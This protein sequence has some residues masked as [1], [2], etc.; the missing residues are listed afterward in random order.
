[1]RKGV[2]TGDVSTFAKSARQ[3]ISTSLHLSAL[4]VPAVTIQ[5]SGSQRESSRVNGVR[6]TQFPRSSLRPPRFTSRSG[7][8]EKTKITKRTH[9]ENGALPKN[10]GNYEGFSFCSPKNEPIFGWV[11][12]P[13][14]CFRLQTSAF[15]VLGPSNPVEPSRRQ[16][17]FSLKIPSNLGIWSLE[18]RTSN[19]IFHP[20]KNP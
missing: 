1:M 2:R 5:F 19:C 11:T 8:R 18:L 9:F 15:R 10:K 20:C 12:S 17:I 16:K 14:F 3:P 13:F 4:R 7:E 6:V